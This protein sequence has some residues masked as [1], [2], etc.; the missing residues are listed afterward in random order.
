MKANHA[1]EVE[2]IISEEKNRHDGELRKC[3][4]L[5]SSAKK[6]ASSTSAAL[7][8]LQEEAKD[9]KL[10]LSKIDAKLASKYHANSSYATLLQ[11]FCSS[12]FPLACFQRTFPTQ[13]MRLKTSSR[14]F[15][16]QG[17]STIA[18]APNGSWTISWL[19]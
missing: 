4:E 2:R 5:L 19:P 17:P 16:L 7:T 18:S 8:A 12:C 11:H 9:W 13:S 6:T 1:S 14:R 3:K 15:G 10:A